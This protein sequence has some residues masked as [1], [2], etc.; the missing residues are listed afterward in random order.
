MTIFLPAD[1][2]LLHLFSINME[3]WALNGIMFVV[4]W[5]SVIGG[6]FTFA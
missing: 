4:Y 1:L 3:C 6:E 5:T 2:Y